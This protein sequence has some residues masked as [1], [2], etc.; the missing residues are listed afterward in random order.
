MRENEI[1]TIWAGHQQ[2]DQRYSWDTTKTT[3]RL[4]MLADAIQLVHSTQAALGQSPGPAGLVGSR[5]QWPRSGGG[6]F[7]P[8]R[9][10]GLAD[11]WSRH[12][13]RSA[14]IGEVIQAGYLPLN[15]I[16]TITTRA[17]RAAP[18]SNGGQNCP[19]WNGAAPGRREQRRRRCG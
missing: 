6:R 7:Q 2:R 14:S 5:H 8:E 15:L 10:L 11:P 3:Y 1:D 18:G 16:Q 13:S 9:M 4:L 17:C 19:W 12:P